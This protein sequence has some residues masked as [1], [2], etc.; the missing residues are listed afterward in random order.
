MDEDS[1]GE[2]GP[3][4]DR[5]GRRRGEVG[6]PRQ[7]RDEPA[8]AG[9]RAR[10]SDDRPGGDP[11]NTDAERDV[12]DQ[13]RRPPEPSFPADATQSA[14]S[15]RTSGTSPMQNRRIREGEASDR[16]GRTV[17]RAATGR[18]HPVPGAA[19]VLFAARPELVHT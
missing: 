9:A 12:R 3:E 13:Q 10:R 1:L 18:I 6:D 14:L 4:K 16:P 2:S 17:V 8:A 15:A 11:D 5:P 19:D 7:R